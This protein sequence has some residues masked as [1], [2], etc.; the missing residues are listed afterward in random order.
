MRAQQSITAGRAMVP[1]AR[2][3]PN[4]RARGMVGPL[5]NLQGRLELTILT[6]EVAG[7]TGFTH[8]H[9]GSKHA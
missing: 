8:V 2:H 5:R 6:G 7:G 9:G 4:A 1:P 3:L